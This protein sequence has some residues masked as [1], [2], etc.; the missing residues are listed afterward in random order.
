MASAVSIL[1]GHSRSSPKAAPR[2]RTILEAAVAAAGES[3]RAWAATPMATRGGVLLAAAEIL[4]DKAGEWG[5]DLSVEEGK[6]LAEGVGEVRRAAQI[7]RYYGNEGDRQAGE[8]YASPRAGEQIL[9]TR[10]PV[11]AWSG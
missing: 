2:A 8:I 5:R 3:V 7:L 10:K 6:T 1:R 11:P 9:V 4:D